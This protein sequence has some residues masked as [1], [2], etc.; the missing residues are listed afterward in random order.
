[1]KFTVVPVFG[2][3]GVADPQSLPKP[4]P[5]RL[6]EL[7]ELKRSLAVSLGVPT[8][9]LGV[10][11]DSGDPKDVN[12]RY[13]TLIYSYRRSIAKFVQEFLEL[14]T[15][16]KVG[17]F[18]VVPRKPPGLDD[19][20]ISDVLEMTSIGLQSLSDAID[21]ISQIV[22]QESLVNSEELINVV[23]TKL[24]GI[25]GINNLIVQRSQESQDSESE[26][27]VVQ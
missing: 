20:V 16:D 3:K 6:D 11:D 4:E 18:E 27:E 12:F 19:M 21:K 2:D 14:V 7:R 5:P 26:E 23:N 8:H 17:K 24:S 22:S 15:N 25:L 1:M 10:T 9:F 13:M